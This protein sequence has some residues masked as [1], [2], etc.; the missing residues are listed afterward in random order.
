[1]CKTYSE[2]EICCGCFLQGYDSFNHDTL[3]IYEILQNDVRILDSK[4]NSFYNSDMHVHSS[5]ASTGVSQEFYCEL[6]AFCGIPIN[7]STMIPHCSRFLID[8]TL[9][10]QEVM[11]L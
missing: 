5:A 4:T 2:K 10:C 3:S 6:E 9:T 1:M 11:I 7:T 8:C